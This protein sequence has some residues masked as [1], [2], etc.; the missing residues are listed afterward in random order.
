MSV[1]DWDTLESR[2]ERSWSFG[3]GSE[4]AGSE[5]VLRGTTTMLISCVISGSLTT[6]GC[7]AFSCFFSDDI[8]FQFFKKKYFYF[9]FFWKKNFLLIFM[10]V[11]VHKIKKKV[12]SSIV[13]HIIVQKCIYKEAFEYRILF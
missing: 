10:C 11:C 13:F 5:I 9:Y 8:G 2:N 3:E 1:V 7:S 4:T 6:S 12:S